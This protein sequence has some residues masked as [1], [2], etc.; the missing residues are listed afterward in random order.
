MNLAPVILFVYNRPLHTQ[1]TVEALTLNPAHQNSDL[2]IIC[3]AA[4]NPNHTEAL[5][6]TRE[7]VKSIKGFRSIQIIEN[8]I[9]QGLANNV[10]H[11][12][13]NL[14]QKHKRIIYLEDD[15][16]P[17]PQFLD[18]MNQALDMY[19]SRPDIFS[20]SGYGP[21]ITLPNH[22]KDS[23]YLHPRGCCWGFATWLNRWEK[24]DWSVKNGDTFTQD[25]RE[26]QRLNICGNDCADMLI[27]YLQHRIDSWAIR[28][29]YAHVQN[30]AYC[31]I[32]K[33]S[34][35]SNIGNDNSGT[36]STTSDKWDVT[37]LQT[38][39]S[40][41]L[42]PDIQ[43]NLELIPSINRQIFNYPIRWHIKSLL[44]RRLLSWYYQMTSR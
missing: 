2:Y 31:L 15:T 40:L 34:L 21:N 27:S 20:I 22:Y 37:P 7:Y 13:S 43:P 6:K 36:H 42:N 41:I 4:R 35:I 16:V 11:N 14:I 24:V 19:K 26:Q 5:K 29:C 1:K 23:F 18:L 9:N 32:P 44:R 39:E 12:V 8:D 30:N 38:N 28:W 25:F 33:R 17:A 3:D 10:I